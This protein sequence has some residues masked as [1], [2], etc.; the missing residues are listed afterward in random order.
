MKRPKTKKVPSLYKRLI[1]INAEISALSN[2]FDEKE[3]LLELIFSLEAGP[4]EVKVEGQL[5]TVE[6]VEQKGHYVFNKPFRL[7]EKKAA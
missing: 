5:K 7:S 2:L 6:V 4:Q 3:E 1:K